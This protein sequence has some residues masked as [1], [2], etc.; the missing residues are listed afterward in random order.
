MKGYRL[1]RKDGMWRQGGSLTLHVNDQQQ[2]MELCL[3]MDQVPPRGLWVWI[4]AKAGTSD[5]IVEVCHGLPDQE[6]DLFLCR[7]VRVISC[8]QAQILIGTFNHPGVSWGNNTTGHEPSRTILGCADNN[9]LPQ[10]IE[11]TMRRGANVG[12]CFHQQE[13]LVRNVKLKGSLGHSDHKFTELE[14]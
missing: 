9:L 12:P 4:K 10:V 6:V 14:H 13:H 2:C 7:Q 8:S 3:G 5:I 11:E 1:F